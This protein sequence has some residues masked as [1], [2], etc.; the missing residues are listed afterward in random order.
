MSPCYSVFVV[1]QKPFSATSQDSLLLPLRTGS[2]YSTAYSNTYHTVAACCVF[3]THT[4]TLDSWI[5]KDSAMWRLLDGHFDSQSNSQFR[6]GWHKNWSCSTMMLS[7]FKRE[8][9]IE[10]IWLCMLACLSSALTLSR[11]V[12]RHHRWMWLPWQHHVGSTHLVQPLFLLFLSANWLTPHNNVFKAVFFTVWCLFYV[13]VACAAVNRLLE[14]SCLFVFFNFCVLV[15][16]VYAGCHRTLS[17]SHRQVCVLSVVVRFGHQW[18]K[19][20]RNGV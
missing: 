16:L 8:R 6:D 18:H 9:Q 11:L 7:F 19:C 4:H 12:S 20:H 17:V 3:Y 10:V 15:C 14:S 1:W 2:A 5:E 13:P